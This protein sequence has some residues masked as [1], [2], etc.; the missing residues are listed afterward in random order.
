LT[1]LLRYQA[2]GGDLSFVAGHQPP[3]LSTADTAG[4]PAQCRRAAT[5]RPLPDAYSAATVTRSDLLCS[6]TTKTAV[7]ALC[8]GFA[9][10]EILLVLGTV[11]ALTALSMPC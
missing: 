10:M 4:F 2:T 7:Y 8:R 11:M 1:V 6:F 5:A 9:G 3:D